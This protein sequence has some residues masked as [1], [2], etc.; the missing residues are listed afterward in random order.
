MN[1]HVIDVA[2]GNA[3]ALGNF[4]MSDGADIIVSA[5]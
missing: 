2:L 4:S 3:P 1:N 5:L